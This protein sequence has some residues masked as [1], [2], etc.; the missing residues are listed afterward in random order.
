MR[1]LLV[2]HFSQ[3][4]ESLNYLLVNVASIALI[5]ILNTLSPSLKDPFHIFS[6]NRPQ[7]GVELVE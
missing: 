1:E 2:P 4:I 7:N 5:D 6:R 3:R